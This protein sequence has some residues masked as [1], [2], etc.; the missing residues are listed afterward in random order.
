MNSKITSRLGLWSVLVSGCVMVLAAGWLGG[1]KRVTGT[2]VENQAPIIWFANIPPQDQRFSANPY[3]YW[4]GQ[5]RDGQVVSYRYRVLRQ[6]SLLKAIGWTDTTAIVP[7]SEVAGIIADYIPILLAANDSVWTYLNVDPQAGQPQTS[8]IVPL[9]AELS[10]PVRV[11]VPQWVF[12]QAIDNQGK[13]SNVGYRRFLRNNNPPSTRILG[14]DSSLTPFIDA[15]IPGGIAT[16]IRL[17]WSATDMLDYP[18]EPPPFEFQWRHYGPYDSA[19]FVDLERRFRKVAFVSRD[20][21]VFIIGHHD[22][23]TFCDT[24]YFA[25]TAIATCLDL[26]VDTITVANLYGHLDTI[27]NID[28]PLFA[29][30]TTFNVISDSSWNMSGNTPWISYTRTTLYDAFRHR[31]SPTTQQARFIFWIRSRDDAKGPDVTPA[32]QSYNVVAP[33]YERDL[34]IADGE[35]DFAINPRNYGRARAYWDSIYRL[36][37]PGS[38]STNFSLDSDYAKISQAQ[39]NV[40]TLKMLLSHKM[41]IFVSDDVYGSLFNPVSGNIF[42]ACDAGVSVWVCGRSVIYGG[43]NLP[44]FLLCAGRPGFPA[45]PKNVVR[46]FQYYFG[47]ECYYYSGWSKFLYKSDRSAEDFIGTAS[48]DADRWPAMTVDTGRLRRYYIWDPDVAPFRA[49]IG[50]LPEVGYMVSTYGT[51]VMHLYRSKFGTQALPDPIGISFDGRPVMHRYNRGFFRSAV[52]LFTPYSLDS[53]TADSNV[54]RMLRWMYEPWLYG[55]PGTAEFN[56]P[57]GPGAVSAEEARR[58]HWE[59]PRGYDSPLGSQF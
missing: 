43:E 9:T 13:F 57:S 11:Y 31:P 27:L 10:D 34:L 6:T 36:W 20:A 41:V 37:N 29:N 30:D 7:D 54:V 22:V 3:M 35:I 33:K 16:G 40:L 1:C 55:Q 5:D 39:G 46:N 4:V 52:S 50:A 19:K 14:F 51:E 12:V 18:T 48:L 49:D 58:M 24:Q 21:R 47:V 26:A 28:D 32:F 53:S 44:P 2:A 38:N 23:L 25:D 8:V 15:V 45:D 17:M 56:F 42:T 59:R